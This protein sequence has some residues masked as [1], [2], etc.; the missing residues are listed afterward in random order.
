LVD[1]RTPL[2]YISFHFYSLAGKEREEKNVF[3]CVEKLHRST[4]VHA[5]NRTNATSWEDM[6]VPQVGTE[7]AQIGVL[8]AM[9][10]SL[11]PDVKL[12]LDELGTILPDVFDSSFFSKI[13]FESPTLG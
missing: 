5:D 1:K 12:S 7:L 11:N 9:R 2:D 6:I 8:I 10:D 4:L 13:R 3:T